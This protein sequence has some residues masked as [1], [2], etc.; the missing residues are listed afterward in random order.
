MGKEPHGAG[1]EGAAGEVVEGSVREAVVNLNGVVAWIG[2][3][4]AGKGTH[5]EGHGGN[6]SEAQWRKVGMMAVT[7]GKHSL[8]QMRER[9]K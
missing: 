1:Q 8:F 7:E 5:R 4:A 2:Q 6:V 3:P 9:E